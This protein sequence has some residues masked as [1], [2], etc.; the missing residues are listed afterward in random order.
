MK[1]RKE[2]EKEIKKKGKK[3]EVKKKERMIKS[4]RGK[5]KEKKVEKEGRRLWVKKRTWK[6]RKKEEESERN[7]ALYRKIDKTILKKYATNLLFQ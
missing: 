7:V 5:R 2:S 4:E 6:R 3:F 1:E